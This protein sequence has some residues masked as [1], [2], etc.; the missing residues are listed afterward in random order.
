MARE[1]GLVIRFKEQ[2]QHLADQLVRPGRQTERPHLP[3]PLRDIDPPHRGEPEA[4]VAQRINDAPDLAQRHAVR[5]LPIGPRRHR[6]MVGIDAAVGQEIQL[7]VEHLPVETFKR[8]ATP[9]A[10]TKDT[11]HRFG[12]LHFAYLLGWYEHPIAWPPLPVRTAFPS[13][14][15]GRYPCDYYGASVT[16]RARARQ[17]IS[18]SSLTYLTRDLG[19]PFVSFNALAG[20]RPV[21]W[22]C[23]GGTTT[24]MQITGAGFGRLSGGCDFPSLETRLGFRQSSF[25]LITPG[26][27]VHRPLRLEPVTGFLACYGPLCLSVPGC[28]LYT[29]D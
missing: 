11:Q 6:T 17:V 5:G 25:R 28:L 16:M 7:R 23:T 4:L 13:S 18:R 3:V 2:A 20:H 21:L 12:L 26:L 29:S 1:L 10:F 24:P 19:V 14:L 8:Q 22:R 27:P 15:A 9:S